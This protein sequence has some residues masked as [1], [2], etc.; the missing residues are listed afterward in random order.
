M[1]VN[2][3]NLRKMVK[4]LFNFQMEII[5]KEIFKMDSL[6]EKVIFFGKTGRLLLDYSKKARK[7]GKEH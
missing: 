4:E 2:G 6:K 7:M 1:K 3:R 5:I